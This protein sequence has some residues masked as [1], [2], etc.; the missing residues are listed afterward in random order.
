MYFIAKLIDKNGEKLCMGVFPN[1][2]KCLEYINEK[3]IEYKINCPPIKMSVFSAYSSNKL[4]VKKADDY[5]KMFGIMEKFI[6]LSKLKVDDVFKILE[7][8][9]I[10]DEKKLLKNVVGMNGSESDSDD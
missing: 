3:V 9:T 10:D 4:R 6:I 2:T 8:L 5:S 1:K 7:E